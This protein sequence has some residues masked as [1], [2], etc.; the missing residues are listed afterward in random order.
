MII[1]NEIAYRKKPDNE[2]EKDTLSDP[3]AIL[4]VSW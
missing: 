1:A 2:T 3:Q 4:S